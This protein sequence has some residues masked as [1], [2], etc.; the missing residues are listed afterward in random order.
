VFAAELS[1]RDP[2]AFVQAFAFV[3]Y[4]IT[5]GIVLGPPSPPWPPLTILT[6]M[7]VHAGVAHIAVNL[8][9]FI[10]LAPAIEALC[11]PL[12]FAAF[13]LL[14]G[15]GGALAQIAAAPLSHLPSLGASGAIAGVMGAYL[16]TYP[17]ARLAFGLPAF[18]LIGAW[19]ALQ[20]TSGYALVAAHAAP[21]AGT[22]YVVHAGGFCV[23]VLGIGLFK[24]R[25]QGHG[26]TNRVR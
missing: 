23:G 12:R 14:A 20:F 1:T 19:A 4:D 17:T 9:F 26:T 10:A 21:A 7:F 22:A 8:L 2:D 11:G 15:I 5:Q 25:R 3:P 6:A 24:R 13:S 16:V 18:V